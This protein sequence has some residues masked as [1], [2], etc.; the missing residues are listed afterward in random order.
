MTKPAA[1]ADLPG[2]KG[3]PLL[4]NL[5]QIDPARLHLILEAWAERHGPRY[6]FRL[7]PKPV[8][9]VAEPSEVLEILRDRPENFRR[10]RAIESVIGEVGLG[11]VFSA[12]GETW[13]RYRELVMQGFDRTHLRR[14]F[15]TLAEI[16]GRLVRRWEPAARSGLPFDG[17]A[18]LMR[19]TVD[20]TT[21]FV[22]DCD[23]NTLER[24]RDTLQSQIEKILP[25][26]NRRIGAPFPYWRFWKSR[27]DREFEA[28]VEAVKTACAG[29]AATSRA[30]LEHA[31]AP[32]ALPANL[33]EGL[34]L[35]A[36]EGTA[37]S[38]REVIGNAVTM[39]L[40]GEDTSAHTLAWIIHLLCGHP[41]AQ[42][43]VQMEVDT[44]P[45]RPAPEDLDR[46]AYLD[47]VMSEA[48]RLKSVAPL[49]FLEARRDVVAGGVALGRGTGVMALLRYPCLQESQ[50][51]SAREFHPDRWLVPRDLGRY[52]AHHKQALMPFG[53][54][55][56]F[57]PG[58][59]LAWVEIKTA[60]AALCRQFH[61][62]AADDAGPASERF[63]FT[64]L[65]S[66]LRI[67]ARSRR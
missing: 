13:R 2:P 46:L 54:G 5:L 4:G 49:L 53:A 24:E 14:F 21:N 31:P 39:L 27:A 52:P 22:F 16:A 57:C 15:P 41:D 65:P 25:N 62:A 11:G 29:F 45:D 33:L 36:E 60:L 20:V 28:A 44:L 32:A 50:F 51:S 58:R 18:D 6:R 66:H 56:R 17:H 1:F 8:L 7:G 35:A 40:A 26:V 9:A 34:L 47:G 55:P 37:F 19:Y 23:M 43:R 12:E 63:G 67:R 30:R 10:L 61:F 3:L 42:E 48:M 64:M 38:E 59:H